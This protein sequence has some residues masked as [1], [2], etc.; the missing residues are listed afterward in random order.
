M[1]VLI[2]MLWVILLQ[3][4]SPSV[5]LSIISNTATVIVYTLAYEVLHYLV[6]RLTSVR[7]A[8]NNAI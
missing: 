2:K 1:S 3:L 8:P 6:C 4:L 7:T 5:D